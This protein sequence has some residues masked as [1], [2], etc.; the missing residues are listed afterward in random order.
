MSHFHTSELVEEAKKKRTLASMK[1]TSLPETQNTRNTEQQKD[2]LPESKNSVETEKQNSVK[3]VLPE[4]QNTRKKVK[5]TFYI[6]EE[7]WEDFN[8]IYG[9]RI[10]NKRK[11]DKGELVMEAIELLKQKENTRTTETQ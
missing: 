6:S 7:S 9:N 2:Q 3:G 5:A 4:T 10:L 8:A 11:T 1:P